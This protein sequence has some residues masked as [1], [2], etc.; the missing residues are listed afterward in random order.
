MLIACLGLGRKKE[1]TVG[2]LGTAEDLAPRGVSLFAMVG[3]QTL[4][5]KG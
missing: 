5:N 4:E 2:A 1:E 3:A